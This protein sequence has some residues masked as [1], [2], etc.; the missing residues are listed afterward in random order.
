MPDNIFTT[1]ENA[2]RSVTIEPVRKPEPMLWLDDHRGRYIPRDFAQSF[3]SRDLHVTGVSSDGWQILERGP[4]DESTGEQYWDAWFDVEQNAI[5]TIEGVKYSLYQDGALWLIPEGMEWDDKTEGFI[6]PDD[7]PLD[8]P[9]WE[10]GF[11]D[12]H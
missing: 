8:P 6:W 1:I 3:I 11:A 4:D 9:G 7:E 10:G 5:V 2:N 12:N